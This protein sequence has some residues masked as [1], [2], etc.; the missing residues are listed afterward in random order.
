MAR[1]YL[2]LSKERFWQEQWKADIE[3][4]YEMADDLVDNNLLL[5]KTKKR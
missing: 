3:K 2:L 4:R 1:S 5:G